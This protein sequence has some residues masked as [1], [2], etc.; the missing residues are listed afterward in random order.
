MPKSPKRYYANDDERRQLV[1]EY[2]P[3][4]SSFYVPT[5]AARG[6]IRALLEQIPISN[7]NREAAEN[8][9]M[10]ELLHDN[11]EMEKAK[12]RAEDYSDEDQSAEDAARAA[13]LLAGEVLSAHGED[14]VRKVLQEYASHSVDRM[15]EESDEVLKAIEAHPVA[16]SRILSQWADA[17]LPSILRSLKMKQSCFSGC[18]G[19][20]IWP[21]SDQSTYALLPEDNETGRYGPAAV[22]DGILAYFHGLSTERVRDYLQG[23]RP[24]TQSRPKADHA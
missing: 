16:D 23:I 18:P 4:L 5:E 13:E 21:P 12:K 6:I 3:H 17:K 24:K 2:T 11:G 10:A 22:K 20:T 8:H 9:L 1:N 14:R 19:N 7:L 15:R